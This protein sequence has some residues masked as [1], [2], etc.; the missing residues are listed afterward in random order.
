[1]GSSKGEVKPSLPE[2]PPQPQSPA[3]GGGAEGQEKTLFAT[4]S[5][6]LWL[7]TSALLVPGLATLCKAPG[8]LC[9]PL[10]AAGVLAWGTFLRCLLQGNPAKV[11]PLGLPTQPWPL[12]S[13]SL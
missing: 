9:P 8:W 2:D 5:P 10:Q 12:I 4:G 13:L 6:V 11:Q 1:M 3:E 7:Q